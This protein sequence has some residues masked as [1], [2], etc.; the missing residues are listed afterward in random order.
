MGLWIGIPLPS[1]SGAVAPLAGTCTRK[2]NAAYITVLS[3]SLTGRIL[4]LLA[5]SCVARRT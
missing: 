1:K 3:V 2:M 5:R 4:R